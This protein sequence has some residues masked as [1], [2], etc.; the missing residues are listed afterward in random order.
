MFKLVL[1]RH[2]ESK[3]NLE[4]RFTG[5]KDVGITSKGQ[6]EAEFAANQLLK[7]NYKIQSVFTSLLK[8]ATEQLA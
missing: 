3:W 4:N 7:E 6:K 5:W 2:G 8:R 1:L